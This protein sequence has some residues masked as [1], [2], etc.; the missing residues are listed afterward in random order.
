MQSHFIKAQKTRR[1]IVLCLGL[2]VFLMELFL[3]SH[4]LRAASKGVLF[5]ML[6]IS[7]PLAVFLNFVTLLVSDKLIV[8]LI[9]KTGSDYFHMGMVIMAP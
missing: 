9:G 2:N 5:L 6:G 3:R 4:N 7:L 1:S 8:D